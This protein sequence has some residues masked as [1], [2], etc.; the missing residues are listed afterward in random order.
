MRTFFILYI[1]YFIPPLLSV[2]AD[3]YV[4]H[5]IHYLLASSNVSALLYCSISELASAPKRKVGTAFVR[6]EW[7]RQGV[8]PLVIMPQ[9][10]RTSAILAWTPTT[11]PILP[12]L[13]ISQSHH[14]HNIET[15]Q[16]PPVWEFYPQWVALG[17]VRHLYQPKI[18]WAPPGGSFV[19]MWAY[20]MGLRDY[21]MMV[22]NW[23]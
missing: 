5:Y 9:I 19:H 4:R 13:L 15:P 21:V 11:A 18:Y 22:V 23:Q 8:R 12:I 3:P 16:S 17:L 2:G 6:L 7:G 20:V 1:F 10:T 14:C